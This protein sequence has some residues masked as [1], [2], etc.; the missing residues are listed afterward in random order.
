MHSLKLFRRPYL[1]TDPEDIFLVFSAYRSALSLEFLAS[2]GKKAWNCVQTAEETGGFQ[3]SYLDCIEIEESASLEMNA[4]NE[5]EEEDRQRLLLCHSSE[6]CQRSEIFDTGRSAAANPAAY[7]DEVLMYNKNVLEPGTSHAEELE[8]WLQS[9]DCA[10]EKTAFLK[11]EIF[12]LYCFQKRC[13]VSSKYG[14]CPIWSCHQPLRLQE[15]LRQQ[16]I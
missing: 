11:V 5:A 6:A 9:I 10:A 15:T 7:S 3:G 13:S 12:F 4:G 14:G 2:R 1:R 16:H 8:G